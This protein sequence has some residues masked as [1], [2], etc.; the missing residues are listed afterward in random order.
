VPRRRL[1]AGGV[2]ARHRPLFGPRFERNR[3]RRLVGHLEVVVG[4]AEVGPTVV[5]PVDSEDRITRCGLPVRPSIDA[6]P[7]QTLAYALESGVLPDWE[8][9]C[10]P[11]DLNLGRRC[12]AEYSV[13]FDLSVRERESD[14]MPDGL[15]VVCR[16][17]GPGCPRSDVQAVTGRRWIDDSVA[18]HI[19]PPGD[20]IVIESDVV[21]LLG[22]CRRRRRRF[23][24]GICRFRGRP[25]SGGRSRRRRPGRIAAAASCGGRQR[26]EEGPASADHTGSFPAAG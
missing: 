6:E 17:A 9:D 1:A 2:A 14:E 26:G 7:G 13:P 25:S 19:D 4:P 24:R 8:G 3:E 12:I 5:E 20:T 10:I 16:G 18:R 22:R 23:G 15:L 21:R 11:M